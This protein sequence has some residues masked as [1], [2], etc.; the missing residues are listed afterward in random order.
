[1]DF[2][3]EWQELQMWKTDFGVEPGRV[4]EKLTICR[5][6]SV[7]D[8][9]LLCWPFFCV[10]FNFEDNV[11][12]GQADWNTDYVLLPLVYQVVLYWHTAALSLFCSIHLHLWRVNDEKFS[13][14]SGRGGQRKLVLCSWLKTSRRYSGMILLFNIGA[15]NVFVALSVVDAVF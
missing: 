10:L 4:T 15:R 9:Q 3:W 12:E 7:G 8:E 6:I 11:T 5:S 2:S 14:W 13:K 1:M